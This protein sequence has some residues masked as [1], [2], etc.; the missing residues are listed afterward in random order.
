MSSDAAGGQR[1]ISNC[2][3]GD[4]AA[5]AAM[6]TSSPFVGDSSS[7]AGSPIRVDRMVREH[8]RR[9]DIFASDAMDTDGAEAVSASAGAFAVDGVQ[10]PGR[11]SP[12]N[13]EDAGGAAAGHA[14]RPPLAG[15]RSGFRRLGLRGMK[16]RLLVV[17]N[18]LPVSANR[19][20][21]DQWSLEI[22]AGGL[23]SALLGNSEI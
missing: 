23:V 18:R 15:S 19:R 10:S 11:A 22:S 4:A 16:Q 9:Y 8:G 13:M 3:R 14:A 20:G 6:P 21:E 5:A 17:A 7:G 12:A 1:S 2:T